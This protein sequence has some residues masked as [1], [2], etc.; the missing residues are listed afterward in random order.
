MKE[1]AKETAKE[2]EVYD[3]SEGSVMVYE[4]TWGDDDVYGNNAASTGK[5]SAPKP[6]YYVDE[7]SLFL[8]A[9]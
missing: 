5:R 6:F 9:L 2:Y 4:D 3:D 1:R 7:V 8:D